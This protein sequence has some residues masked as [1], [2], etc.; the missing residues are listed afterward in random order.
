VKELL[1]PDFGRLH[2][3]TGPWLMEPQAYEALRTLLLRTDLVTH[4]A[5]NRARMFDDGGEP[6]AADSLTELMPAKGGRNIAKIALSGTLMKSSSSFGG[7]STV[8][9]RREINAAANDSTVQ[10]ILLAI[11]SPGGT[12]SGTAELGDTI[13]AAT[14]QKPV[15]AWVDGLA[16]SAAYWAASQADQI[17]AGNRMAQIGSIGTY[18]PAY[19]LSQQFEKDGIK[20]HLF[21]TGPLKGMGVQG[22]QITEEQVAHLQD[23]VNGIQ[24]HFDQAVRSGRGLSAAELAAVRS[25]AVFTTA[26]ALGS[27]LIDGTKTFEQTFAALAAAS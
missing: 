18:M 23:R 19:D 5:E 4:V 2:D 13:K 26:E 21:T 3:W 14:R 6:K 7:T 17:F 27:K 12:A 10:G 15:Y 11:D 24:A 22:T 25:G 20:T 9:A 8:Q 16:A 1:V